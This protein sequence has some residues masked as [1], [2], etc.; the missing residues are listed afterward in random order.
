MGS[1]LKAASELLASIAQ[2]AV[3]PFSTRD[4]GRERAPQA[5]SVVVP[6]K[7]AETLVNSLAPKLAPGLAA[8]VGTTQWLGDEKH[9]NGAEVVVASV[10]DQFDILRV[11]QSDAINYDMATDDLIRE[12]EEIHREVGIRIVHAETDTIEFE[13]LRLPTPLRP[14]VERLYEL[15]P[16]SVDQGTGSVEAWETEIRGT[17]RVFLWWD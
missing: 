9:P 13:V 12:L 11:A 17:R 7:S 8:F 3:R 2:A 15:C 14:F 6:Q 10:R 1:D 5:I 4:F 16:D